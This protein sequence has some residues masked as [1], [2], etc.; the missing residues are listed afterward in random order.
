V[1]GNLAFEALLLGGDPGLFAADRRL[2]DVFSVTRAYGVPLN[3]WAVAA[4][5]RSAAASSATASKSATVVKE[6]TRKPF[7][8]ILVTVHGRA[9]YYLPHGSC[10]VTTSSR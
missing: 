2:P 5:L 10:S 9:L 6:A 3:R 8:K 4:V 7:G 1:V